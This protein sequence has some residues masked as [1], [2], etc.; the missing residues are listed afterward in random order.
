MIIDRSPL[1]TTWLRL[2]YF[3]TYSTV[4]VLSEQGIERKSVSIGTYPPFSNCYLRLIILQSVVLCPKKGILAKN[5]KIPYIY[6]MKSLAEWKAEPSGF[7]APKSY[8]LLSSTPTS[9]SIKTIG[10][11]FIVGSQ[12]ERV[13]WKLRKPSVITRCFAR[14]SYL[15]TLYH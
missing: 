1:C 9:A 14:R 13:F 7:T 6:V 8:I 2:L 11:D 3:L 5:A 15:I 4:Q 10:F 12:S